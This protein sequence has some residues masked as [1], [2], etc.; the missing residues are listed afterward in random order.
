[1]KAAKFTDFPEKDNPHKVSV[2]MIYDH[3]HGQAVVISL[4]KG[5]GLKKHITPVD[6]MFY[7]LE[8]V[9]KVEIGDEVQEVSRDMVIES[10][11]RVPHRL[12]NE[13]SPEFR[14]LVLKMPKQVSTTK[15]L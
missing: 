7:I 12:F 11:A 3:D 2:R 6:V 5:E 1:M 9:G 14:F 13:S 8:G 4:K 10:P 15:V